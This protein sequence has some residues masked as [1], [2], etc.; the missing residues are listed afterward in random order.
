MDL[1]AFVKLFEELDINK[2]GFLSESKIEK[3]QAPNQMQPA[4]NGELSLNQDAIPEAPLQKQV[5][6]ESDRLLFGTMS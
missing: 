1:R 2:E 5:K 3:L 6:T 4:G